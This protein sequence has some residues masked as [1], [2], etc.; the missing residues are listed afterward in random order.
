MTRSLQGSELTPR[1]GVGRRRNGME[2]KQ[3]YSSCNKDKLKPA[4]NGKELVLGL[5]F[6]CLGLIFRFLLR[7][8]LGHLSSWFIGCD[9]GFVCVFSSIYSSIGS[10]FAC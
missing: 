2:T 8:Y 10:L 7:V 4:I 3:G 1:T 5:V 6:C 9:A